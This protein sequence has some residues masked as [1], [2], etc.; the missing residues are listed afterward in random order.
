MLF[1]KSLFNALILAALILMS[2]G[3]LT[4]ITLLLKDIKTK[5]LW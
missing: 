3:A 4:L 1:P 2:I 5:K